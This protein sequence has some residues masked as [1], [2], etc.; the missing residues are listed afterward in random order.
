MNNKNN[1][2]K[3]EEALK[4]K[5]QKIIAMLAPSFVSDFNYPQ[6]ISQLRT[7]GFDNIVEL[8]FG[9]KMINREY[10]KIIEK[11]NSLVISSVCPGIV[12]SIN[13]NP[14]LEIY[15]KNI[16]QVN[17]PMIATAK[18]CKKI[19]PKHKTCFISPCNFK[20]IE[21]QKSKEV[22]YVIDY[23]QLKQL[24]TKYNINTKKSKEKDQFDKLY[25]DYTKIYPLSGGLSKTAHLKG[26]I[27]R[28]QSKTIDGWKDVSKFLIDHKNGKNKEI[29]F[30]DVT[31][32]KGGCIGGPCT[33]QKVSIAKKK[34]MILKYLKQAKHE[35][36]PESKKGL[37]NKAKGINF[38]N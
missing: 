18:I 38:R 31:F 1:I 21:T 24:F 34:K 32:C 2:T 4:D 16:I 11:S 26:I 28:D 9:A 29:L 6:I 35:D 7:L 17:S 19:Y 3:I 22:D 33:N 30:L 5:K 20:K 25:N 37:I 15:K 27:K 10:H 14:E 8:T 12:E 36:I 23:N 13:N